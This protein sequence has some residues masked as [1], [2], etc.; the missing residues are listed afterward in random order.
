[1]IILDSIVSLSSNVDMCAYNAQLFVNSLSLL[2]VLA[3]TEYT[4]P[5]LKK[6]ALM[7][8]NIKHFNYYYLLYF[9]EDF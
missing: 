8:I 5:L 9:L 2:L 7:V 6:Y 1:M 4:G 3:C